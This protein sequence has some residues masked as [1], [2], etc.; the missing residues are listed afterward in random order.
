[1]FGAVTPYIEGTCTTN[2]RAYDAHTRA[3]VK[4]GKN[5]PNIPVPRI[6]VDGILG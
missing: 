4:T 2:T 3:R 6:I 5:I 1:M